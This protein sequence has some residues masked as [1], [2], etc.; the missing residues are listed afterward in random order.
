MRGIGVS[1]AC[2]LV[3]ARM[4]TKSTC[5]RLLS[6][7]R[8]LV[9]SPLTP[10]PFLPPPLAPARRRVAARELD[11]PHVASRAFPRRRSWLRRRSRLSLFCRLPLPPLGGAS[12]RVSRPRGTLCLVRFRVAALD[13]SRLSPYAASPRPARRRAAASEPA[14]LRAVPLAFPRQLFWL[15]R[16]SRL[17]LFCRLPLPP[18]GAASQ[19]VSRPRGTLCLVRVLVAAP[20]CATAH[21]SPLMPPPPAPARRRVAV[22]EPAAPS[23]AAPRAFPRRRS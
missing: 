17:F 15:H 22:G 21:A 12:Q 13:C 6:A 9:A 1:A 20:D 8:L 5:A 11:A 7:A 14:A 23:R 2:A 10:L 19:R 16:R 18:L 3:N 4:Q